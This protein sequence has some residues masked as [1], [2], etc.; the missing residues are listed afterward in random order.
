M[1]KNS[2]YKNKSFNKMSLIIPEQNI[3]NTF[4][5]VKTLNF[6]KYDDSKNNFYSKTIKLKNP[7]IP[8]KSLDINLFSSP[9]MIKIKQI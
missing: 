2:K 3:T 7:K 1:K 6:S 9:E 8:K 4:L 5:N